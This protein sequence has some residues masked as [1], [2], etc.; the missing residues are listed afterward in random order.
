MKPHRHP[1]KGP[2]SLIARSSSSSQPMPLVSAGAESLREQNGG[3]HNTCTGG[4]C[5]AVVSK[6]ASD[7]TH[8]WPPPMPTQLLVWGACELAFY[9]IAFNAAAMSDDLCENLPPC[10]GPLSMPLA[11][12]KEAYAS[13][14]RC[15]CIPR[16]H[17]A[18]CS[19]SRSRNTN[20]HTP[21]DRVMLRLS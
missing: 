2:S 10:K 15:K 9:G 4:V 17:S 21:W 7:V 12:V 18:G 19:V 11:I 20:D 5:A 3:R 16:L 8:R 6:R 1:S 14:R 13:C